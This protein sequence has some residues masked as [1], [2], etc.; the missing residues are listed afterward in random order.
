MVLMGVVSILGREKHPCESYNSESKIV[1]GGRRVDTDTEIKGV[2]GRKYDLLCRRKY[3]D[4]MN[5]W[6]A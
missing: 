2:F 5:V 1:P 4:E 6:C 3:I